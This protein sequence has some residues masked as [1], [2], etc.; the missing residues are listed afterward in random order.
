MSKFLMI[1][2]MLLDGRISPERAEALV[3]AHY[4]TVESIWLHEADMVGAFDPRQF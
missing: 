3:Q 4:D 2:L 1:E